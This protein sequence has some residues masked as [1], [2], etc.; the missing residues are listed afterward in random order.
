[1]VHA[2]W[3]AGEGLE[4]RDRLE[5]G[6][7][8]TG[9][10]IIR[11]ILC[12]V[13]G[14]LLY[15]IQKNYLS[16]ADLVLQKAKEK[17]I[18]SLTS[19][20]SGRNRF[21]SINDMIYATGLHYK[22]KG[23]ITPF[24][25]QFLCAVIGIVFFFIGWKL[26]IIIAVPAMVFGFFVL[27]I[28]LKKNNELDNE[29]MLND[30][31]TIYNSL[32][33]HT[34]SG[35]YIVNAIY[36]C[37]LIV[38]SPRLTKALQELSTEILGRQDVEAAVNNFKAKF[39]NHYIDILAI[40]IKQSMATGDIVRIFDDMS[41]QIDGINDAMLLKEEKKKES[42]ILLVESLV[43]IGIM[44]IIM[45]MVMLTLGDAFNGLF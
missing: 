15:V 5:T 29:Q 39:R 16:Q 20:K 27:G 33:L 30:I 24:E 28:L 19:A 7:I 45:Y 25:Y 21:Q 10:I 38:K 9:I 32:K 17:T 42:A 13:F 23:R 35:V 44:A 34:R 14:V 26:H 8:T 6:E 11:F 4:G 1:M 31:E 3:Y 43:F 18:K 41:K 37:H 12:A 22:S 40:A 36:E 2:V